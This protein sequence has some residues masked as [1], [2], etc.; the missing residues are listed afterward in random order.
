MLQAH[1]KDIRGRLRLTASVLVVATAACFGTAVPASAQ[2]TLTA[3]NSPYYIETGTGLGVTVTTG[4]TAFLYNPTTSGAPTP[5]AG[6]LVLTRSSQAVCGGTCGWFGAA[7]TGAIYVSSGASLVVNNTEG[8]NVY[9]GLF[10]ATGDVTFGAG[11][12]NLVGAN[13]FLGNLTL[14]TGAV[15]DVGQTWGLPSPTTFGANTNIHLASGSTLF[16]NMGGSFTTTMGGMIT[17]PDSSAV[18]ELY[19]GS[20][21]INGANTTANPF[22]GTFT[23]DAGAKLMIGD[24]THATAVFGDPN[25]TDGSAVSLSITTVNGVASV[26][27][28]YGT[29]YATVNN[30]G[31]V[32][33]GGT[34][35]T[36]GTLT[37]STYVQSST[38]SLQVEVSPTGASKLNV[39]GSATLDGSLV[40][41]L[42]SGTYGNSVFPILSAGSISGSFST[43]STSGSVSGAIVALQTTTTGYNIVT[44]KASSSQVIGHLVTANR[45]GIYAFTSSLYDIM[46]GGASDSSVSAG[47]NGKVTTWLTPTGRIDNLGRDGLGYGLNSFGVSVGAQY[48]T[49]WH[50]AVIGLALGYDHASLDVKNED[51]KAHSNTVNL[52]VY[53]GAD[54]MYARIDGMAFYNTYDAATKRVMAGFGTAGG[55]PS[56]WGWGGSVQVSRALFNNRVV[57]FVRGTFARVVQDKLS[58]SG[59]D[60]FDL[61]YNMIDA[62]TFVGDLGVLVNV[63]PATSKIKLQTTVA[64]RHDFSDPGETIKGSFADLSGSSFTYH[65]KG[66][67]QNTLLI[68]ANAGG[69]VLP[70]LTVFGRVGGEFTQFRRSI[71]FGIGARYHF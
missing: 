33:P 47:T 55:N 44:E 31:I 3:G 7:N 11:Q 69:E 52:A 21:V 50:N 66:D 6:D 64:L 26:L 37:V 59:V 42:D 40:I 56:G 16:L 29:I 46:S 43:V 18:L 1:A 58:E 61:A 32:K 38:G 53:G 63:L 10:Q 41:V 28:G 71:N 24:A 39:L 9:D 68:G 34:S 67:A 35:G 4:T 51:T 65:W 13:S 30:S 12:A 19:A 62:N 45:N 23:L 5:P 14:E 20:L 57:P 54:V 25:H 36:L 49:A 2:V 8:W 27:S 22:A 48:N 70:N 17:A 15:V 60:T